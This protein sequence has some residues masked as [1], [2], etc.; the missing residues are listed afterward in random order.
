MEKTQPLLSMHMMFVIWGGLGVISYIVFV[1][2]GNAQ[3]KRKL[4]PL[5]MIVTG[6]TFLLLA[7]AVGMPENQLKFA[8]PGVLLVT[9]LNIFT[10]RFCDSCGAVLRREKRSENCSTCGGKPNP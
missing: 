4:F 9:L 6:A 5:F 2:R 7:L 8:A 10:T 3:L 1:R